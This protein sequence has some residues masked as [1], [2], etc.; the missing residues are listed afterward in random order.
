MTWIITKIVFH[1]RLRLKLHCWPTLEERNLLLF[2]QTKIN[3][4]QP[5]NSQ[6]RTQILILEYICFLGTIF[7]LLTRSDIYLT[8]K[9]MWK[10]SDDLLQLYYVLYDITWLQKASIHKHTKPTPENSVA[11]DIRQLKSQIIKYLPFF[12]AFE[13]WIWNTIIRKSEPML[14]GTPLI[15]FPNQDVKM[16]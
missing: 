8:N 4:C 1:G 5:A 11:L 13:I 2:L 10:E 12:C 6:Q 16:N 9:I 3:K 15:F 7:P 14:W